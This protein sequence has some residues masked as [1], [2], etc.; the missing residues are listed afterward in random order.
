ML[1]DHSQERKSIRGQVTRLRCV[2][3][4]GASSESL[5]DAL[6]A[7]LARHLTPAELCD[8]TCALLHRRLT[9]PVAVWVQRDGGLALCEQRGLDWIVERC[10]RIDLPGALIEPLGGEGA[11]AVLVASPGAEDEVA[12]LRSAALLL[13]D[14]LGGEPPDTG[15]PAGAR[16]LWQAF[17]RLAEA[18]EH[19]AVLSVVARAIGSALG[20][21]CVQ[22]GEIV[23]GELELA[24]TWLRE[25]A[26]REHALDGAALAALA[27][28]GGY[29]RTVELEGCR[30]GLPLRTS[31]GIHG[32]L[33]GFGGRAVLA[34]DL[35]DDSALLVAHAA[36]ALESL[37]AF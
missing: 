10:A 2:H 31:T 32:Y 33:V 30:L 12:S 19:G 11:P 28:A 36:V 7:A 34:A 24:Q 9:V 13:S 37:R 3:T 14:A 4:A 21:A 26:A 15:Q 25:D 5:D 23:E 8:I 29:E 27:E 17:A 6:A 16:W 22:V 18:R 1:H 20:L 35:V